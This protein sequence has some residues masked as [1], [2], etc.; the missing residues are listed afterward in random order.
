MTQLEPLLQRWVADAP[1]LLAKH[2]YLLQVVER[3]KDFERAVTILLGLG[4]DP[5]RSEE[6]LLMRLRD[7]LL[8]GSFD[9]EVC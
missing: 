9:G 4:P 7:R 8:P 5:S 6:A 2:E 3:A 1:A